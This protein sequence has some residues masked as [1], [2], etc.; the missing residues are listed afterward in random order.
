MFTT[1]HTVR[2]S[3]RL[4]GLVAS[5]LVLA[6]ALAAPA[7]ART[8][9]LEREL[10]NQAP[11]ILKYLREHHYHHVGVLK[12]RVQKDGQVTDNAGPLNLDVASWLE[13]ALWIKCDM[14]LDHDLTLLHDASATA[15]K[16]PGANH[17]T[18]EGRAH[19]FGAKYRALWGTQ[20]EVAA[21]AFLAGRVDF[22]DD[23][24]T[25]TVAVCA[26][27]RD[28]RVQKVVVFNAS[29]GMNTLA[30]AGESFNL[31]AALTKKRTFEEVDLSDA[32]AETA[33]KT[34]EG[35]ADLPALDD[36]LVG[37]EIRYVDRATQA[38]RVMAPQ[39]ADGRMLVPEP[40]EG[41]DVYFVLKRRDPDPKARYGVVLMVNGVNTLFEER[42]PPQQCTK[43][44]IEP[45]SEPIVIKG[46][47]T[48]DNTVDGFVVRSA[49]ESKANEVN[50]GADVGTVSYSV[51][52]EQPLPAKKPSLDN[53]AKKEEAAVVNPPAPPADLPQ[54]AGP[55]KNA[56]NDDAPLGLLEKSGFQLASNVRH[57]S[58]TNPVLVS[59]A[60]IRY[61]KPQR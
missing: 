54:D 61:Y 56:L 59:T 6:F 19:L 27:G 3:R 28:N 14:E 17:L 25:L 49:A 10:L 22:S 24:R 13:N 30:L 15:A 21:D 7:P 50:Y 43:W 1:L 40:N 39:S 41:Q 18:A 16:I 26:L 31:R 45:G 36:K 8:A 58:F 32:A 34:K 9:G 11:D 42:L 12:F 35:K 47:Q 53:D 29:S 48:T 44:I 4:T 23:L 55:L 52:R 20:K 38:D 46:F 37:L 51:F 60:T 33:Q 5:A 57:V 2:L